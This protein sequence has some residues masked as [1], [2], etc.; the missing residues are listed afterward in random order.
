MPP[1]G[2]Q[3]TDALTS[4]RLWSEQRDLNPRPPSP[5]PGALPA[6]LCPEKPAARGRC[7]LVGDERI[8]LPQ[9]E[10]ESAALPLCKSPSV[11]PASLPARDIIPHRRAVVNCFFVR[12]LR[13]AGLDKGGRLCYNSKRYH[14]IALA[15]QSGRD[16]KRT[17]RGPDAADM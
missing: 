2:Q 13:R 10:S 15:R 17:A 14:C 11:R 12:F 3:K 6:A 16:E 4:I 1:G 5:E 8:E 9:T 7:G